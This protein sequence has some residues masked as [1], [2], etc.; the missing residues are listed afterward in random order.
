MAENPSIPHRVTVC[1]CC[2][3]A[4]P[5]VLGETAVLRIRVRCATICISL[6][7]VTSNDVVGLSST[8][9][10]QTRL[11]RV[12]TSVDAMI[13]PGLIICT[14]SDVPFLPDHDLSVEV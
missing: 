13:L 4:F 2:G 8:L 12:G 14:C 1:N 3:M 5:M 7:L 11:S 6:H 10:G 9:W